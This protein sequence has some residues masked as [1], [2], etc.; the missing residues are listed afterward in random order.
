MAT[1]TLDQYQRKMRG[2][3]KEIKRAAR[4]STQAAARFMETTAKGMAPFNRGNLREGIHAIPIK[5]AEWEVSSVVPDEFPYH[6]WVNAS[7]IRS[8]PFGAKG[9]WIP[10]SKSRTGRW[11]RAFP[12][13]ATVTYGDGS[14]TNTG[15]Y[16]YWSNA[17]G[18]TSRWFGRAAREDIGKALRVRVI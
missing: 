13:F 2:M 15:S 3:A 9:G 17:L 1:Y 16:G 4:T 5:D 14:H 6:F 11:A 7:P 8:I 12:P 10:P 18:Q